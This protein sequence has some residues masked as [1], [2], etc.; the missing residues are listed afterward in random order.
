MIANLR[1]TSPSLFSPNQIGPLQP[2]WE[3]FDAAADDEQR[4]LLNV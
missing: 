1:A 4:G 2:A 3:A